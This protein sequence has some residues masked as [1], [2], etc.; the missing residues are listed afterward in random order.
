MAAAASPAQISGFRVRFATV[1]GRVVDGDQRP[2][3][4]T[5]SCCGRPLAVGGLLPNGTLTRCRRARLGRYRWKVPG[6]RHGGRLSPLLHRP[7]RPS[8]IALW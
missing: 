5:R 1:D 4:W 3:K 2:P 7:A 6:Q 8:R